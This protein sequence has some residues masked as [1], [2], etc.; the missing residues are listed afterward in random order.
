MPPPPDMTT[1]WKIPLHVSAKSQFLDSEGFYKFGARYSDYDGA[2]WP[3]GAPMSRDPDTTVDST[4]L[5]LDAAFDYHLKRAWKLPWRYS[6]LELEPYTRR[7]QANFVVRHVGHWNGEQEVFEEIGAALKSRRNISAGHMHQLFALTPFSIVSQTW[8]DNPGQLSSITDSYIFFFYTFESFIQECLAFEA[9]QKGCT[10]SSIVNAYEHKYTN[11]YHPEAI[12][13]NPA[14][15]PLAVLS[16]SERDWNQVRM[17]AGNVAL[18]PR[19]LRRHLFF[20]RLQTHLQVSIAA[21]CHSLSLYQVGRASSPLI[22]TMSIPPNVDELAPFWLR[23]VL[24]AY[25]YADEAERLLAD[26][27]QQYGNEVAPVH[28]AGGLLMPTEI[29]PRTAVERAIAAAPP[30][31]QKTRD[32]PQALDFFR[33]SLFQTS[34]D[35]ESLRRWQAQL[36][37]DAADRR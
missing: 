20:L 21:A 6:R 16:N 29:Q 2:S 22:R 10:I 14:D 35:D 26:L 11:C 9:A 28:E 17:T 24:G 13:R 19:D 27:A 7:S 3:L 33:W 31:L 36:S 5:V 37:A 15:F 25:D 34:L 23:H 1:R 32:D 30:P 12:S 8:L 4:L 18:P